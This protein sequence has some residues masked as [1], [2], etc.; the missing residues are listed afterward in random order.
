MNKGTVVDLSGGKS[1]VGKKREYDLNDK[2]IISVQLPGN[3]KVALIENEKGK[4]VDIRKYYNNF[5]T[6]RGI[7]LDAVTF[8]NV[9][10]EIKDDLNRIK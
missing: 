3:I 2:N 9:I 5:P 1:L 6:R 4:F 10:E 8:K 7:R